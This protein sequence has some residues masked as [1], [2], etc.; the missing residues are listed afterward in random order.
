MSS[1]SH[2]LRLTGLEVLKRDVLRARQAAL[3]GQFRQ[4]AFAL[5]LT[6]ADP[7]DDR[8]ALDLFL[9]PYSRSGFATR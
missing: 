8:A 6:D 5:A 2:R 1:A 9:P 3:T 4:R 7:D